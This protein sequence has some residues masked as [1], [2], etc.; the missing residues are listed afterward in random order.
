MHWGLDLITLEPGFLQLWG[1]GRERA[2]CV[3]VPCE[4]SASPSFLGAGCQLPRATT[5]T[6]T[7][8]FVIVLNWASA[9]SQLS[10]GVPRESW[11]AARMAVVLA[12]ILREFLPS[13]RLVWGRALSASEAQPLSLWRLEPGHVPL[14]DKEHTLL[15]TR[16]R[17]TNHVGLVWGQWEVSPELMSLSVHVFYQDFQ[18]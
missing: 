1:Q 17:D 5:A 18:A 11:L 15:G 12:S 2:Y 7:A 4:V 10:R 13:V 3:L 8:T 6:A 9:A 14:G 16:W